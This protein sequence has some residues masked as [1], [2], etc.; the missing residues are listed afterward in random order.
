MRYAYRTDT[1]SLGA[2][3]ASTPFKT[4]RLDEA[5]FQF[6]WTDAGA[7]DGTI[8]LQGSNNAFTGN[9]D[10]LNPNV[11]WEDISA[12]PYVVAGSSSH[13]INVADIAYV[14]MRWVWTRTAGT[15]SM[16][17]NITAKAQQ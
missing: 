8:K 6:I 9:I 11:S 3:T 2:S 10:E 7:L 14:A 12:S 13:I 16:T 5:A 17:V 1:A 4:E 15:G